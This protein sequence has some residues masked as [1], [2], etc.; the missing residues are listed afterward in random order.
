MKRVATD[1]VNGVPQRSPGTVQLIPVEDVQAVGELLTTGSPAAQARV[2]RT[3]QSAGAAPATVAALTQALGELATV[4]PRSAPG[5]VLAAASQFDALVSG[6][7]A[8]FLRDAPGQF[9]AIHVALV[10]MVNA[11]R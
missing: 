3:L 2:G 4:S 11:L 6:V 9:L 10:A 5:A 7:P 1:F 8:E